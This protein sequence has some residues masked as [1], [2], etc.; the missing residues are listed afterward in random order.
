MKF[1]IHRLRYSLL[2]V[3]LINQANC[4]YNPFVQSI[5]VPDPKEDQ[6][7]IQ[8]FSLLGLTTAPYALSVTGQ[9]RDQNG[10]TVSDLLLTVESRSNELDG[11]DATATTNTS[12]R[13][14][15]RLAT[16]TTTFAVSQNDSLLFKFS[17]SVTSPGEIRVTEI[18]DNSSGAEVSSFFAYDPGNQPSFFELISSDPPNNVTTGEAPFAFYF[19][20]SEEPQPPPEGQ[21]AIWLSENIRVSPSLSLGNP[22]IEGESLIVLVDGFSSQ[23]TN[24]TITLGSGIIGSNS[25]IPL[26]PRTI[27]FTCSAS[28][29]P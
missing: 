11:L 28:C 1:I 8:G 16:G 22:A 29:G 20:F 4:Y 2:L 26:T 25:G 15:I 18:K 23:T 12:G 17:I 19:Y 13:F 21:E 14:F 5:L 9:I 7:L 24:Y 10:T 3:L 27:N 6:S